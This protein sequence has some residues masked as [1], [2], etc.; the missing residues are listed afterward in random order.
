MKPKNAPPVPH[1]I[2]PQQGRKRKD[3][4]IVRAF[5]KQF[6]RD[7]KCP[8]SIRVYCTYALAVTIGMI[9]ANLA[10]PGVARYKEQAGAAELPPA[11]EIPEVPSTVDVTEFLSALNTGGANADSKVDVHSDG[12]T[13]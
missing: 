4:D 7:R 5:W 12:S 11:P 8:W 9:P 10:P 6:A 3:D 13:D 1:C 2:T